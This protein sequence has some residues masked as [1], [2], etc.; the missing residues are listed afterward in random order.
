MP[1]QPV[2]VKLQTSTDVVRA[3]FDAFDLDEANA[4]LLREGKPVALAPTPFAVLC[5]LVRQPG[6]LLTKNALLDEV[7]GHRFV[8]ESVLKTA[9]S[10]IRTAL[11][12]DPRQPRFIETVS[13]RGYRFI[14]VATAISTTRPERASVSEIRSMQAPLFIGR[15]EALSRLHGAWD[16]ACSGRRA[17]VWVVGEPGVG[18]T[19]LIEHFVAGLGDVACARGQCVE[20]YG[21][22]EPYLPVLEALAELC[23]R[24]G[25]V[26]ALLRAVAPIW[27]LQLPWL[28]TVEERDA[29]RR[30]LAGVSPERMLREMGELLDRFTEHRPLLLVTEDL[31]WSDRATVQLLAYIARRR[32]SAHLMWLASFR[33]AEMVAQEHPLNPM[34]HELRLHG[35]GEEI[36]LDPFSETEVADVVAQRAPA[37]AGDEAFVRAL[38][39]RTD[40]VPLFVA[41][42]LSDVT[43]GAEQGDEDA[44]V[45]ARLARWAVPERLAAII[46]HYMAKLG[47]EPRELLAAAAVCGVEFRVATVA[48]VL[49]RDAA[50]VEQHCEELARQRLWLTAPRAGPGRQSTEPAYLFRHA[51]FRQVMYERTAPLARAQLHG[52]VGAALERERSEGA[53]VTAAELAMHFERGRE[54]MTALRY[55]AEA[56][57]TALANLIP[58]ECKDLT[59]CALS[60]LGRAPEGT[61]R[62]TLEIALATLC[63]MA[64]FNLLGVGPEAKGAFQRAYGLLADV[65]QHPLRGLLLYGF[66]FVL[67]LR[68]EYGEALAVAERAEAWASDANDPALLL[69]AC[70]IQAHV[71]LHQGRPRAGRSKIERALPA[72]ESP[73]AGA[74]TGFV[75]DPPVTL[76]GL[77]AI[78]LLHLGLVDQARARLAQAHARAR[79]GPAD[80]APDR[81]L[82]RRA[83]R[84]A[85][86]QRRA[87]RGTRRRD[88]RARRRVRARARANGESLVS[89][90]GGRP[91]GRAA[92]GVPSDSRGLRGQCTARDAGG[93]ERDAGV[94]C[95]GG[96]AR[97]RL[98]CGPTPTR[99]SAA[100]R[101]RPRGARLSATTVP[102]RGSGLPRAR[103]VR[104]RQCFG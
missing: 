49:A 46:E 93:R 48:A 70:T 60:L 66:G 44:G 100:N 3:H 75:A 16:L 71:H 24:D 26:P 35:L 29:L 15:A 97:R 82:V 88:A 34:R 64:D 41:S 20:H 98:G 43:A 58:A 53:P 101:A 54:P 102:A 94:R 19:M 67:S 69:A 22:G 56:A 38:H 37:L 87:R 90:L 99:G 7:W 30:E 57:G 1:G 63:G 65:P 77:L 45:G 85:A 84:A 28:S 79:R 33:L 76:L 25:T 27:L 59:E 23:R 80:G 8:S 11:R 73:A 61:E 32:G 31:H 2:A 18:K 12:D 81:H 92:R 51:L 6:A 91:D 72:M 89:R 68:T 103:R 39:E 10:E 96:D 78:H 83:V 13:R 14:A 62:N 55:Y 50:W 47:G 21:T 17:V 5:A 4:S 9:I 104:C 52:K 42:V 86:R 74:G 40:G 36:V 95:R